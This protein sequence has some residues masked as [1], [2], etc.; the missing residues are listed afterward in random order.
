MQGTKYAEDFDVRKLKLNRADAWIIQGKH[1]V[2][3]KN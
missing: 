2:E 1:A 3:C